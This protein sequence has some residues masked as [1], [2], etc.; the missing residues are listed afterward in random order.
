MI[1][2]G[3]EFRKRRPPPAEIAMATLLRVVPRGDH[4]RLSNLC[5]IL[6]PRIYL[7][8]R[9]SKFHRLVRNLR[10]MS[11]S[12]PC[13]I[14]HVPGFFFSRMRELEIIDFHECGA[15]RR[16][17]LPSSAE[18]KHIRLS[19]GEDGPVCLGLRASHQRNLGLRLYVP[20][21]PARRCRSP[22]VRT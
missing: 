2:R 21:F 6:L 7:Y 19:W 18:P 16:F 5:K 4:D 9:L 22:K 15:W 14:P 17:W 10:V 3:K 13:K 1:V 12:G 11:S 20:V 8:A